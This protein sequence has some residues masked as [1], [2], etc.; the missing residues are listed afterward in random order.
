MKK[1]TKYNSYYRNGDFSG[2]VTITRV[3]EKS[4]FVTV[5]KDGHLF[6]EHREGINTVKKYINIG[7]W[8]ELE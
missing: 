2:V 6:P 8:K 7:I 5:E 3:T 4:V 1:G